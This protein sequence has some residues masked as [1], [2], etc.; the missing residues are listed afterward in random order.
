MNKKSTSIKRHQT[1]P[2]LGELEVKQAKRTVKVSNALGA[3]SHILINQ[4]T[5]EVKGTHVVTYREVDEAEFVK[6]FT[7][8]IAL[9]FDLT[10]AG[11]KALNV[12]I[13]AV[14]YSAINK[15]L[16]Q[17]D[18]LI[19]EQFLLNNK[20]LKLSA[21]TF[22]RGLSE[23][24]KTKII[25]PYYSRG[26]YFINPN[27]VFNGDRIAFTTAIKK[28]PKLNNKNKEEPELPLL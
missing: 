9:T 17:L 19:L 11:L 4:E 1:N 16:V 25:A 7:K 23:L 12:L 22:K 14:Q 18:G 27:F 15:D 8:N 28:N 2:F 10:S 24:V 3:D 21:P 5:G 20:K 13:F 6:L 26:F